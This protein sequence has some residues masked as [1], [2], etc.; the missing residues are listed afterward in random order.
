MPTGYTAKIANGISF[1]EFALDCARQFGACVTIRD[2]PGGGEA[3][4]DKFEESSFY[5][6]SLNEAKARLRELQEMSSAD[7]RAAAEKANADAAE[8]VEWAR[9]RSE[10]LRS[11]YTAM[12]AE[13]DAWTPPTADHAEM[14]RFMRKQIETSIKFDCYDVGPAK[15]LDAAD[16]YAAEMQR[17]MRDVQYYAD[18]AVKEHDRVA[19]RNAWIAAL[20]QSLPEPPKEAAHD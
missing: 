17:A 6:R 13:V 5:S 4:P 2:A 1:R 15:I 11:K 18:E 10:E 7:I 14:K 8:S 16:W 9:R 20:R 19:G 12:L 3:I